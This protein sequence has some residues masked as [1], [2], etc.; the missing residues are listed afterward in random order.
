MFS[1]T[2]LHSV[3]LLAIMLAVVVAP[4]HASPD[5][6]S[7]LSTIDSAHLG[8]IDKIAPWVLEHTANGQEAEYLIVLTQQANLVAADRLPT[9][10]LKGRYVYDT[11]Y[12]Q[13][14]TTQ[15]S[16]LK[17]LSDRR[18]PHRSYYIVNVI[19]VKADR[20]TALA[21]AARSDVAR[22]E[23]NP[24]IHMIPDQPNGP[25]LPTTPVAVEPNIQYIHAP[26]VWALGFTGQ[27]I[28]VGGQDT[29]YQW[30]HP[31]L[32]NQYRGW[33]GASANHDYNWHDSIHSGGGLT[34]GANSLFPCDDTNHGTHTMGTAV[35]SDGGTN[36]IGVAPGAKWIGCRNMDQG[37]GTPA[38]YLECFEFFLAPYPVSGTP[39]QG[40]P[41]KAPDVT[42]NSWSCPPSEG[43]T[44]TDVFINAINAQRAAG[45]MTVVA[46]TNSGPSCSTITDP[47]S[48][49]AGVYT[50]GALNT[51]TDTIASFS[52]RGPVT[53]DG[54]NRRKPDITA[55]GTG[56]RSSVPGGGYSS[57]F[58]G[59]S[60][61]TPHVAGAIAL[62]WSARPQLANQLTLT[63]QILNDSAVHISSTLCSSSGWPNNV[64]GYGRLDVL[65][66]VN[67]VPEAGG[68]LN[69]VVNAANDGP[70]SGAI[71]Q[72]VNAQTQGITTTDVS[73]YY[74]LDLISGTYTVTAS[75]TG[76]HASMLTGV[77]I[78][79]GVTATANFTLTPTAE[80]VVS[81]IVSDTLS[82]APLN[83]TLVISGYVGAPV[84]TNPATG[85]YSVTLT[86][87]TLY[88][89]TVSSSGY[90]T[91]VRTIGPLTTDRV[92][93]F[94]L[95]PDLANCVAPGY[96]LIGVAEKFNAASPPA[97]WS[98]S[99]NTTG[100]KVWTF[101]NPGAR[102]NLTG[103][104]GNFAIADSDYGP[105][106]SM[107]TE[108][109]TPAMNLSALNAVTL[110]FKTDFR[111]LNGGSAEVA[112]VD[113]S[114][115]GASGP[116]SNVWRKTGDYRG[117]KTETIDLTAL[118][119]SQPN[120]MVRFHYYNATDEWWWQVDDVS[121]GQCVPIVRGVAL[122]PQ[123]AS[124]TGDVGQEV[125]Y[126]LHFTNTGNAADTFQVSLSDHV[127][128]AIASPLSATLGVQASALLLITVTVP[129]TATDGLTDSVR[130]TLSGTT[131]SA[132]AQLTTTASK[133]TYFTYLPLIHKD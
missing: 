57:A 12:R 24:I 41:S 59:T 31:A 47:P 112:D 32:K 108:L 20:A 16:L 99:D 101:N 69:G 30:D 75:A 63:E 132:L 109:R 61:A 2:V 36:Q 116:W 43:C 11:L 38:T 78:S 89:F 39:A 121:L 8:A 115:N 90:Q 106:G 126:T 111:Y 60:M 118:T 125:A 95:Q 113:V 92:E 91:V 15:G 4:G 23:G 53:V 81:G 5:P 70:I 103:G 128:P 68:K 42:T 73:G 71:V 29:G 120:V 110:T 54:S 86:D 21:L 93:D 62:L 35:G 7:Q 1:R 97:G 100:G 14:Q 26:D 96:T 40:D 22:I 17:W 55:P 46:A 102:S 18:I 67:S 65:A 74:A 72:A 85:Y 107:D 58:S 84:V 88:T 79:D 124:Q 87:A 117:P 27:G 49:Y 82:G 19:W 77:Q 13:A 37:D 45:I 129:I 10:L 83:A 130:V 131:V 56:I 127:W 51:G 50:V 105:A 6:G 34:C 133:T 119:A 94:A 9:K 52:S 3:A 80:H 48:F 122:T 28:V 44:T 66:A 123:T 104:S 33:N 64:Y 25:E 76:F 114:V 98:I